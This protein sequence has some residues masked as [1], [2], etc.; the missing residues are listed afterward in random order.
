MS[1]EAFMPE[2]FGQAKLTCTTATGRVALVSPGPGR[3]ARLYNAGQI[4]AFLEFGDATVVATLA[5]S[6]P[7]APGVEVIRIPGNCTHMAGITSLATTDLYVTLG[8]GV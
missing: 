7:Y 1:G 2:P 4:P 3:R 5:T 6:T 8:E